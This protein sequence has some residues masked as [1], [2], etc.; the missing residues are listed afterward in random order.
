MAIIIFPFFLKITNF[1]GFY[2]TSL[3]WPCF[4]LIECYFR[5]PLNQIWPNPFY[6][7]RELPKFGNLLDKEQGRYMED[8]YV[9][10]IIDV[11]KKEERKRETK[12]GKKK[13]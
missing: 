3:S 5:I 1:P 8:K 13:L 10:Y 9:E 2:K 11:I 4:P 6:R 7:I 12:K